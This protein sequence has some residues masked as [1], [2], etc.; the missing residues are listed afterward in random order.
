MSDATLEA[1]AARIDLLGQPLLARLELKS[2]AERVALLGDWSALFSL[3]SGEAT[4]ASGTLR[5]A[6]CPVP[7]GVEQGHI[8]LMRLDPLL[9]GAWSAEQFLA[10]SAELAGTARK[11]ARRLAFQT[12]EQ[13]G[14]TELAARRLAHLQLAERRALLLAHA[15]LTGP[16]VL[17]VEQPL[18]G[19]DTHA[20]QTLL[21]VLERACSGRRLLVAIGNSELSAAARHLV[22]TCPERLRLVAGV[23]VPEL[24]SA[25][26]VS[27]V[28]ATVCRNHQ[29]FAQALSQR[30]LRAHATHEAGLHGALT[31]PLAGPCWRYLVELPA[32]S[33]A[34]VLDAALETEAGLVELIPLSSGA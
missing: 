32:G 5:I 9:P 14:L 22:D 34:P 12:L 31:S 26:A 1:K 4:L 13:L 28:T 8:G 21:A 23:V 15:L 25:P 33:T 2:D 24:D 18:A 3:L 10:S 11:S 27:R 20:E 30:G 19:L 7:L 17:C 29:A 6:G 16:R